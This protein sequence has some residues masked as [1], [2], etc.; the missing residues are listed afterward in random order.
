ML[1]T[2][3]GPVTYVRT[4]LLLLV[5]VLIVT[6]CSMAGRSSSVPVDFPNAFRLAS[7][8]RIY[9]TQLVF[10]SPK[11]KA[12][13]IFDYSK[14][15]GAGGGMCNA[16]NVYTLSNPVLKGGA[17]VFTVTPH[18]V[19]KCTLDFYAPNSAQKTTVYI[20]VH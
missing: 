18:H 4:T 2:E 9:P 15:I 12:K 19:G 6:S 10:G 16:D 20:T 14:K 13:K 11:G 5:A 7:P 3:D 8:P 17:Q 1:A